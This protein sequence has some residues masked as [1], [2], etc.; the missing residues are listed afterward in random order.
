MNNL[1]VYTLFQQERSGETV[2]ERGQIYV[3]VLCN[4]HV[5]Y[6]LAIIVIIIVIGEKVNKR[7][8]K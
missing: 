5:L 1:L 6:V 8:Y 3:C 7:K 4:I 2:F